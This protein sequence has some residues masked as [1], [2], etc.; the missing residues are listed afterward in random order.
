MVNKWKCIPNYLFSRVDKNNCCFNSN[1]KWK[2]FKGLG[3]FTNSFWKH[4]LQCW[5]DNL[6]ENNL[7]KS[8]EIPLSE[9]CL[10][11]NDVIRYRG[12]CPFLKD[13]IQSGIS[14]V[15]DITDNDS[16][17]SLEALCTMVKYI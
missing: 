16:I 1:L 7:A 17:V 8:F 10:W 11:N 9:Q 3:Y 15:G 12:E 2:V 6:Q 13:W 14:L 5:L 4:V